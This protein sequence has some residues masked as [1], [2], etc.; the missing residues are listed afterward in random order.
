LAVIATACSAD[1]LTGIAAANLGPSGL[2][3]RVELVTPSVAVGDS[4]VARSVIVNHGHTPVAVTFATRDRLAFTGVPFGIRPDT[5]PGQGLI[6]TL[7]LA[8]GDSLV[9]RGAT[10]PVTAAPG[11]YEMRVQQLLSPGMGVSVLVRV[12][13]GS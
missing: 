9:A 10:L 11:E 6:A 13:A 1:G 5:L 4:F 7:Q 12:V 3:Q 2:E 8:P